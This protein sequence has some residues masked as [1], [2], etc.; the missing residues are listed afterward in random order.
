MHS[1]FVVQDCLGDVSCE[2]IPM[3]CNRVDNVHPDT[4]AC[5]LYHG[6]TTHGFGAGR[7]D[8]FHRPLSPV[9]KTVIV[10]CITVAIVTYRH[11]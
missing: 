6:P 8:S 7:T 10:A 4:L 1:G 11:L 9:S 5:A 2:C 3:N